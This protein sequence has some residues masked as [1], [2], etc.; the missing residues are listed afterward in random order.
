MT[1]P[2]PMLLLSTAHVHEDARDDDGDLVP[3]MWTVGDADLIRTTNHEY[4]WIVFIDPHR[5]LPQV[6]EWLRPA[7]EY[8]VEQDCILIDFDQEG[9]HDDALPSWEW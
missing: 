5:P 9:D 1:D 2:Q 7:W 8:A 3:E 4:G 6:P